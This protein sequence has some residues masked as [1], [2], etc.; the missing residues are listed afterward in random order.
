M[1]QPSRRDFAARAAAWLPSD[2]PKN[3]ARVAG[4]QHADT[5]M[6]LYTDDGV[7][8]AQELRASVRSTGTSITDPYLARGEACIPGKGHQEASAIRTAGT[9]KASVRGHP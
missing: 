7:L 3:A 1:S 5:V 6:A 2:L 4:R 9:E 8:R